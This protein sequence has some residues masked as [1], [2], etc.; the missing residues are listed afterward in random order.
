MFNRFFTLTINI[1]SC[2]LSLQDDHRNPKDNF[3][4]FADVTVHNNNKTSYLKII[5][6]NKLSETVEID[7]SKSADSNFQ[8]KKVVISLCTLTEKCIDEFYTNESFNNKNLKNH[9]LLVKEFSEKK[10][11]EYYEKILF[12]YGKPIANTFK[13]FK[14]DF[15]RFKNFRNPIYNIF[16]FK[17]ISLISTE[18][19]NE[20]IDLELPVAFCLRVK[21]ENQLLKT[22]LIKLKKEQGK[23]IFELIENE[24]NYEKVFNSVK[25]R[26]QK[27]YHSRSK[28]LMKKRFVTIWLGTLLI[29]IG[30]SYLI[31]TFA[32]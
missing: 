16:D 3:D 26:L 32:K 21:S 12:D 11:D 15:F 17:A 5:A 1:L 29:L 24:N 19:I 18:F 4:Y 6:P 31:N 25:K 9:F 2:N 20:N 23:L 27:E 30:S 8:K 28:N 22:P 13:I 10:F 14:N 7:Y